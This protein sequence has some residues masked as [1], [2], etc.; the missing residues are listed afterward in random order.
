MPQRHLPKLTFLI[1]WLAFGHQTMILA[2]ELKTGNVILLSGGHSDEYWPENNKLDVS[3]RKGYFALGSI[4]LTP[5]SGQRFPI[6]LE[7]WGRGISRVEFFDLTPLVEVLDSVHNSEDI[8]TLLLGAG[9]KK[10][11]LTSLGDRDN[12]EHLVTQ[13]KSTGNETLK[14]KRQVVYG[15]MTVLNLTTFDQL[16]ALY[17]RQRDFAAKA[18]EIEITPEKVLSLYGLTLPSTPRTNAA[19]LSYFINTLNEKNLLMPVLRTKIQVPIGSKIIGYILEVPED[20]P[21]KTSGQILVGAN[22]LEPETLAINLE[23]EHEESIFIPW[24]TTKFLG[25][26]MT[27]TI[28]GLVGT[29]LGAV[30]GYLG[31]LAQ[32]KYNRAAEAERKFEEKKVANSIVIRRFF[33]E[34]YPGYLSSTTEEEERNNVSAIRRSFFQNGIYAVLPTYEADEF[35]S[36]CDFARPFPV[37]GSRL[38]ALAQL[39]ER[40]FKDLMV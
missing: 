36:I 19:D 11:S 18:W 9:T 34:E 28:T 35:N 38:K 12:L 31:F 40:R 32:Q 22:G 26:V 16:L 17:Q 7:I 3:G 33:T 5:R 37:P 39:M 4:S 10:E 23:T 20:S 15:L 29:L 24:S 1:L 25:A 14:W 13:G 6:D 2:G 21:K 8:R 27:P 30:I